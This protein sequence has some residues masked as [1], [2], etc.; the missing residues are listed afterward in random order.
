MNRTRGLLAFLIL[1]PIVGGYLVY[2]W[3]DRGG[4]ER[5][6]MV[7]A[8][9]RDNALFPEKQMEALE[10]CPGAPFVFPTDGM[11]GFLWGDS[12]RPGRV[13]QGIDIFPGTLPGTTPV[14]A[15]YPGFLTRLEGWVSTVIIRIPS[16]PL[17]PGRQIWTYYTHFA[18]AEG[19]SFISPDFP[20]GTFEVPVAEGDFLGFQGN[21]SGNPGNPTGVHLHF[22]IVKDDGQGEFLNELDID[23][24]IDPSDYLG[25]DLNAAENPDEIPVCRRTLDDV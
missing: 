8:W 6:V 19:N 9:F 22:S 18:D 25:M 17:Q 7:F 2:R 1:V 21:Y 4:G 15:A 5:S 12:F 3:W 23:N 20:A 11:V 10:R 14:Y 16:D 24:T 13:H